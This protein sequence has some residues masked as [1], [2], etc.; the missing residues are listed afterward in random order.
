MKF[1]QRILLNIFF[2]VVLIVILITTIFSYRQIDKISVSNQWVKHTHQVMETT[3]NVLL[4]MVEV[5]SIARLYLISGDASYLG[6]F[7]QKVQTIFDNLSLVKILTQENP[8]QQALMKKLEPL[9][10]DRIAY[11]KKTIELKSTNKLSDN[12]A[13]VVIH[14]GQDLTVKIKEMISIIY[15]NEVVLLQQREEEFLRNFHFTNIIYNGVDVVNICLLF[16]IMVFLNKM[17]T[18]LS[19]SEKIAKQSE[20]LLKGIIGGSKEYIAAIDQNY[21]FLSFNDAFERE[22]YELFG[23]HV[24][25]G[26]NLKGALAHLP[27]EQK[28]S[29]ALW[30]RALRGEEFSVIEKFGSDPQ[31]KNQ[32]EVTYNS[33]YN[34][35]NQLIGASV[36]ARDIGKRMEEEIKLKDAN[37]KL[38][39]SLRQ[40]ESQAKEMTLINDMNNKLRSSASMEETLSMISLYLKKLLPFSSGVI[41]LINAPKKYLEAMAEWNAPH[42]TEKIFSPDQCWGLRQGKMYFYINENESIAC[43]HCEGQRHL[44]SYFCVP[45]LAL[46]EVIGVLHL[47]LTESFEMHQEEI[48]RFYEQNNLMIQNLAGQISLA[49]SNI[50]LHEVLKTR[51]SRDLLTNLYNRSYLNDTFERDIQRAKRNNSSMAIVMMDLDLF[52]NVNDTFGHEAGDKVLVE[53]SKLIINQMRKSDIACRYGGEEIIIILYDVTLQEAVEKVE[54]LKKAIST[55]EF[56]FANASVVT[57]SFG[58][59]MFPENGEDPDQLIKAADT[60]MYHSKKEGRNK[61]TVYNT[62]FKK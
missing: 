59:A 25:V 23:K 39:K 32:Y 30:A 34:E 33:I 7:D 27:G 15:G 44:R 51:S 4:D 12:S 29:L 17:L 35:K 2:A 28:K 3:N 47:Q 61:V 42:V 45:L 41:Y 40:V 14:H 36:I 46:N 5:E 22:F 8:T 18:S 21:N 43:K 48:I 11:I 54:Q 6:N 49:I 24:E 10:N 53:I 38:E 19:I 58:I 62:I 60:A 52:K 56:P 1:S 31:F 9:L 37:K 26:M 13:L 57:A 16:I 50:K 20:A 55:M